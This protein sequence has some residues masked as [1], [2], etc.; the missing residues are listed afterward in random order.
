MWIL[1]DG[2]KKKLICSEAK[3][4]NK[5]MKNQNSELWLV[6]YCGSDISN[7]INTNT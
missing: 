7:K 3:Q 4:M 1:S 6:S 5:M 2:G